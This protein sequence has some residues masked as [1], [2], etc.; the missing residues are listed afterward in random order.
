MDPIELEAALN[1]VLTDLE[2]G[3]LPED[4]GDL[5]ETIYALEEDRDRYREAYR[6]V[7]KANQQIVAQSEVLVAAVESLQQR[8]AREV[9]RGRRSDGRRVR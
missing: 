5:Q 6:Y 2:D 7:A 9:L 3:Y 4:T 8:L 1:A